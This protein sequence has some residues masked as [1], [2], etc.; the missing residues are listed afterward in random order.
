M[1]SRVLPVEEWLIDFFA[2]EAVIDGKTQQ[3]LETV[4]KRRAYAPTRWANNHVRTL[5]VRHQRDDIWYSIS[6]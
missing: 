6:R 2:G 4:V 3:P 5:K 1:S